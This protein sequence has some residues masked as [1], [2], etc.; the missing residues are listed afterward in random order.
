MKLDNLLNIIIPLDLGLEGRNEALRRGVKL[1]MAVLVVLAI[2]GSAVSVALDVC[3]E[4]AA[5]WCVWV[6]VAWLIFLHS[7]VYCLI[8]CVIMALRGR[9][10][11]MFKNWGRPTAAVPAVQTSVDEDEEENIFF[12]SDIDEEALVSYIKSNPEKFTS[13][14]DM[15]VFFLI[16]SGRSYIGT[17]KRKFHEFLSSLIACKGCGQFS[18]SCRRVKEILD[19]TSTDEK[20]R[21]LMVKYEEMDKIL[22]E[23]IIRY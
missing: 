1:M 14:Q 9:L 15:A 10:N 18:D 4:G 21:K 11:D 5:G 13:G 8:I 6:M 23:F 20:R 19:Y 7:V 22:Q 16:M 2:V 3:P 12:S 17:N